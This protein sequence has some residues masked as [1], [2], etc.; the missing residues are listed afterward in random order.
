[1]TFTS[2]FALR[3]PFHIVLQL[4]MILGITTVEETPV[5]TARD[6]PCAAPVFNNVETLS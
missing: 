6:L 1:L 2:N 3:V 4:A 5:S